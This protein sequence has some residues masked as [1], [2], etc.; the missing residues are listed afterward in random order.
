VGLLVTSTPTGFGASAEEAAE[1]AASRMRVDKPSGGDI[2]S[3]EFLDAGGNVTKRVEFQREFTHGDH[4]KRIEETLITAVARHAL[5]TES[6]RA[7]TDMQTRREIGKV[8]EIDN[9]V[10]LYDETGKVLFQKTGLECFPVALSENADRVACLHSAPHYVEGPPHTPEEVYPYQDRLS[11]FCSC[12]KLIRTVEEPVHHM[13][14]VKLS[15][16][17]IWLAYVR[18][19]IGR[20]PLGK[21]VKLLNLITGRQISAPVGEDG[22]LASFVEVLDDGELR[23]F[24]FTKTRRPDGSY[25]RER[26]PIT[27]F[28]AEP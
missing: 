4:G 16:S 27:L 1:P 28:R 24:E 26:R 17:G 6:R 13:D 5:V 12:G 23:T 3:L 10:T 22:S 25:V 21:E 19:Q 20:P 7:E 15:P 9:T 18:G 11:V 14:R 2:R 8:W